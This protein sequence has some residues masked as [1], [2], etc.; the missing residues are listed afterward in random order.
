[1]QHAECKQKKMFWTLRDVKSYRGNILISLW[2]LNHEGTFIAQS[3]LKQSTNN[4]R[5]KNN[6]KE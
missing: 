1:M 3:K 5:K 6:Y 2:L 4:N